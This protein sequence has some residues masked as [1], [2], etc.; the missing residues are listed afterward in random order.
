MD[1]TEQ[2]LPTQESLRE[3]AYLAE[4]QSLT[5]IGSWA[6]NFHTKQMFHLSTLGRI[7]LGCRL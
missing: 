1:V 2:E 3:I 5:P 7:Q 6:T 4:A